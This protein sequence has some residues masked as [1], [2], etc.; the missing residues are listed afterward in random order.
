MKVLLLHLPTERRSYIEHFSIPEPLAQLYLAPVL[1]PRHEIVFVDLRIT[2]DLEREVD[3]FAFGA[4]VVGV[5]PMTARALG[6][7]LERL[8]ALRPAARILL[9]PDA[10]YGNAHVHER[11]LDFVHPLADALVPNYFLAV[12]RRTVPEAIGAFEAG[13]SLAGIPGLWIREAEA[14]RETA[15]VPNVVGDIGVPERRLLGRARG[16]YRFGGV[17]RMAHLFYTYGCRYKC[18]FCPMSKHDGSITVRALDDV[19]A[20]LEELTEPHVYLQDF[21]PFLAPEAMERLA[22][23]VEKADVQKRWYMMTRTDT[24]LEQEPLIRR[25]RDLGLRWLYLGLDGWSGDRLREL[26]KASTIEVNEAAVQRMLALGLRVSLGFVVRSDFTREDFAALR[27][28][29]GRF[30]RALVGF[31]VETPYV[32]TKLFDQEQGRVTTRDWSLYDLEHAVLP[33]ALPL[34]EFYRELARL[35]SSTMRRSAFA[36]ERFFPPR[37][38]VRNAALGPRALVRMLRSGA[39][40][41]VSGDGPALQEQPAASRV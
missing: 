26:H 12:L 10:E 8:R 22:D 38:L 11:P 4:V 35:Q 29:A 25:W 18:R 34:G 5:N 31:T 20:E 41:A 16:R 15:A 32:G 17:G 14:W 30:R 28:Y 9:V 3:G 33:T 39:D 7:T 24:A 1:E 13:R 19:I 37:D 21:E 6:P 23:A 40:H 2:P 36:G 27:A